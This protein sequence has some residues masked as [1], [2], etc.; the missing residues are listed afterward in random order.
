MLSPRTHPAKK[1]GGSEVPAMMKPVGQRKSPTEAR[2][3]KSTDTTGTKGTT[4]GTIRNTKNIG[5]KSTS[6]DTPMVR[7]SERKRAGRKRDRGRMKRTE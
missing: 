7:T 1:R 2:N 3:G 6:A 4:K 5:A